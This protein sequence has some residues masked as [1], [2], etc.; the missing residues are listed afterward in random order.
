MSMNRYKPVGRT[1]TITSGTATSD[2]EYLGDLTVLGLRVPSTFD[3]TTVTFTGSDTLA[4]TYDPIYNDD[5]SA[6][7]VTTAATRYTVVDYTKFLGVLF[8]KLVAGTSQTTTDTII[9]LY[10]APILT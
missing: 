1:V 10:L 8:V 2:A 5:G 7:S 9:T 6:Y 3:G 4:G